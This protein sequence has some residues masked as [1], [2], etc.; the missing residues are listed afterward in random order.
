MFNALAG[1]EID[2]PTLAPFEMVVLDPR[3]TLV[4]KLFAV[5][6]PLWKL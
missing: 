1:T 4:E 5:P 2:D 6:R 3:R